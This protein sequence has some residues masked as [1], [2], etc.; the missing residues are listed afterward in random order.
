[1]KAKIFLTLGLLLVALVSAV[2][3]LPAALV[4]KY[5]P[6]PNSIKLSEVSGSVWRGEAANLQI[7]SRELGKVAL[8]KILWKVEPGSLL[9][10]KLR[11]L[12]RFGEQSS[13]QARGKGVVTASLN[14]VGVE[15]F[16]LSM[17]ARPLSSWIQTPVPVTLE[18]NVSLFVADYQFSGKL[19]CQTLDGQLNWQ[20]ASAEVMTN[21][22]DL[23][24]ASAILSC[25]NQQLVAK[26]TQQSEQISS[27]FSLNVSAPN[28]FNLSGWLMP[29][30]GLSDSFRQQLHWLGSPDV[31][32]H[33]QIKQN[34]RW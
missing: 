22:L 23:G 15:Q 24:E 8:G 14:S 30:S 29:N 34:G 18:G 12:F 2:V 9:S 31:Q 19:F 32:N 10:G 17:P 27:E 20:Q 21:R 33:Y 6:F 16:S 7:S 28:R 26:T 13:I 11:A 3:H 1:M 5:V 25:Q 4:V